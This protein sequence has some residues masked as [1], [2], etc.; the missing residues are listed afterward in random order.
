MKNNIIHFTL[1][2]NREPDQQGS[3]IR[4]E[5]EAAFGLVES[6]LVLWLGAWS[7]FAGFEFLRSTGILV[8]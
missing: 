7:L 5:S 4:I 6:L 8:F 1:P 3:W 2:E